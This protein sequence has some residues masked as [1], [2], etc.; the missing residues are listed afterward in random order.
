MGLFAQLWAAHPAL[1]S[2]PVINPCSTN[3]VPNHENQCAIRLGVAIANGGVGLASY[4]GAFCWSGHGRTH[5]LRVEQM[6]LWL[7]SE[8]AWFLP[9]YAEKHYRN[10]RGLQK[11]FHYFLGRQGIVAFL[12][13]WGP[14]NSG[15]H[16]D[17]W[18]GTSIAHGDL[19]YFERS[20]E[21]W[22]WEIP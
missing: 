6:K 3:G 10:A 14:G 12:N 20:Q 21:L 9:N 11:T 8:E 7:D 4:P 2:P 18:D 19:N 16:I 13:F 15:D 17:L 22:F 1:Q 5:A